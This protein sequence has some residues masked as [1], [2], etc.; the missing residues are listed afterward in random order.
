MHGI[1]ILNVICEILLTFCIVGINQNILTILL[2]N[3]ILIKYYI[4]LQL[5]CFLSVFVSLYTICLE[6]YISSE[7]KYRATFVNQTF[8][9]KIYLEK[10]LISYKFCTAESYELIY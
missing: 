6:N 1:H 7:Y 5:S 2:I 3:L 4:S 8:I 10:L 9:K